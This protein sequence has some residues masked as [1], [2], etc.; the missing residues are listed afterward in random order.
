MTDPR[1][2]VIIPTYNGSAW[3]PETIA[4]VTAQSF[5]SF[6]IILVDDGSSEPVRQSLPAEPRLRFLHQKNAGTSVARNLALANAKGDLIAFLDHD[7]LWKPE[8]LERQVDLL[9]RYPE[10]GFTF[11]D[12]ESFGSESL[13]PNGFLRGTLSTVVVS[14]PEPGICL[15]EDS[16]IFNRLLKDLFVQIPSTWMVRRQLL[17]N[18]GGFEPTLRRGSEDWHLA[19]RLA[20]ICQ[21]AFHRH[22]MTKRREFPQSLSARSNSNEEMLRALNS[23]W[24]IGKISPEAH[25]RVFQ[26][27]RQYARNLARL[28][29]RAAKR[30]AAREKLFIALEKCSVLKPDTWADIYY[31]MKSFL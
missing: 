9:D 22:A 20:E 23:L 4:S 30:E 19:L 15:I 1:V 12:Y 26:L 25:K 2:S 8:K 10:I 7:D 3:L 17:I 14:E 5:Q 29:L 18:S 24:D 16:E 28:D 11:C 13:R 21:F 6:E 31:L 27:R